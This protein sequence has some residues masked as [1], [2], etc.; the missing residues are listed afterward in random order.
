VIFSNLGNFAGSCVSSTKFSSNSNIDV[1][2]W[3]FIKK[4]S[5]IKIPLTQWR[6]CVRNPIPVCLSLSLSHCSWSRLKF[7]NPIHC[8]TIR[9]PTYPNRSIVLGLILLSGESGMRCKYWQTGD[10]ES[11]TRSLY[12]HE[13]ERMWGKGSEIEVLTDRVWVVCMGMRQR[14]SGERGMKCRYW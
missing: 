11:S 7:G 5:W 4:R 1:K 14:E 10:G 8:L 9:N 2:Q 3:A 12:R 13:I 6:S